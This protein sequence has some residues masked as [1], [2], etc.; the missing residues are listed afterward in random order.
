MS[1]RR[2]LIF[3][4]PAVCTAAAVACLPPAAVA[5]PDPGRVAEAGAAAAGVSASGVDLMHARQSDQLV[6]MVGVNVHLLDGQTAYGDFPTV[7]KRLRTLGVRHVRTDF[8]PGR[9]DL[10]TEID[11]MYAGGIHTELVMSDTG[12]TSVLPSAVAALTRLTPHA[13]DGVEPMNEWNLF[14]PANW[15]SQDKTFSRRLHSLVRAQPSL[16]STKVLGPALG[17]RNGYSDLGNLSSS[18]DYGNIHLYPGGA[19]PTNRVTENLA[20][21][22]TV[23]GKKPIVVTEAGYHNALNC[24]CTHPPITEHFAAVYEPRLFLDYFLRGSVKRV[25]Q[26]ELYDIAANPLT[27]YHGSFGLLHSN[28]TAKPAYAALRNLIGLTADQGTSFTPTP[29]AVSVSPSNNA[30]TNPVQHVLVERRNGTYTLFVWRDVSVWDIHALAPAP[31]HPQTATITF[32]QPIASTTV[33]EPSAGANPVS[34]QLHP[35]S[36]TLP[37]A[38]QVDAIRIVPAG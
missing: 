1:R 37:L 31:V 8:A 30:A 21:E 17:L 33:Y 13:V 27:Q 14:G 19:E 5:Q 20:G 24:R 29:L 15:A 26:Y 3:V 12:N 23:A 32:G 9:K 2:K 34:T 18:L 36:L 25:Y 35:T 38:G 6:Q 16:A 22:A 10:A 4:L 7:L 28:G 11:E